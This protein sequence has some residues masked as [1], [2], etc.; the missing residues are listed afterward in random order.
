MDNKAIEAAKE[1]LKLAR[2][3][4]A[5]M[6]TANQINMLA[7][8]WE[9]F[10]TLQQQVFLRLKK[11]FEC[12]PSKYWSDQLQFERRTDPMLQYVEQARHANE[13]GIEISQKRLSQDYR[14]SRVMVIP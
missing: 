5:A 11:A 13:H 4:V 10:L 8:L 3:K 7:Q 2:E 9:E 6:S 12:G 1:K 14:S